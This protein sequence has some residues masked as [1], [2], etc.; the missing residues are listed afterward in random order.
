[1]QLKQIIVTFSKVLILSIVLASCQKKNDDDP[2]NG[3]ATVTVINETSDPGIYIQINAG[4]VQYVTVEETFSFIVDMH[5][6]Y[7]GANLSNEFT[8]WEEK[9][10]DVDECDHVTSRWDDSDFSK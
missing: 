1:M 9:V 5:E 6:L 3:E 2:C 10:Y 4:S 8:G 7:V